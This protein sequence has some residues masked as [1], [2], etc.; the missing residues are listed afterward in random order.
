LSDQWYCKVTDDRL[1]GAALRAMS[2]D[3]FDGV[4]KQKQ[5]SWGGQLKFFPARYA[6][7]FQSWHENIRDWCISRQLWWGHRI[8]VWRLPEGRLGDRIGT[9]E[10]AAVVDQLNRW[11]LDKRIAMT[12]RG[13]HPAAREQD[14]ADKS[15][16]FAF[17]CVRE[18]EDR[19]V[20][21]YLE[22]LGAQQD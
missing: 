15:L 1:A 9:E 18:P 3:Q 2:R 10:L 19:E 14:L 8:P 22:R 21:D 16:P 6:K 17:V 12:H 13:E 20:I 5:A 7:T 11:M 4:G